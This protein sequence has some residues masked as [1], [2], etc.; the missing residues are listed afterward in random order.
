MNKIVLDTSNEAKNYTTF[1]PANSQVEKDYDFPTDEADQIVFCEK[2]FLNLQSSKEAKQHYLS[3][4]KKYGFLISVIEFDNYYYLGICMQLESDIYKTTIYI[5]N[6]LND[7]IALA[8]FERNHLPAM[9][10]EYKQMCK[11]KRQTIAKQS[12]NVLNAQSRMDH[13]DGQA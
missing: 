4:R 9:R 1:I 7:T 5:N 8:K 10:S 2:L 12:K 3:Q 11:L 6:D 13:I